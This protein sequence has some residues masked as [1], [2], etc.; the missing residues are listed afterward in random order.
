[1]TE[2]EIVRWLVGLG[3]LV[4]SWLIGWVF[5]RILAGRLHALASRTKSDLDDLI[6]GALQPHI[7]LW[8]LMG[9]IALAARHFELTPTWVRIVDRAMQAAFILSVSFAVSSFLTRLVAKRSSLYPDALPATSL[10][11]NVVR[12]V[13]VGL[14]VMMVVSNLGI[15]ITPI[16]TALGVGSLAVALALQPT[17][18][19]LFAGF[20]VT[21]ARQIR[22]GDYVELESGEKGYVTDIGWR[23]TE[24]RE[25]PN[26]M[27]IVPN[28]RI[29]EIIVKNFS[30]PVNEQAAL[31]QVGVS[32]SSDLEKVER[33]TID[34]AKEVQRSVTGAVPEFEPFIRYNQFGDSSVNFTVILRVREFVDRYAVSHE[35]IKRLHRRYETEDIEIP[36]PQRVVHFA[37]GSVRVEQA[38]GSRVGS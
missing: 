32:Y 5:R 13:V 29:A 21:L 16:L 9:G 2:A 27:I 23:N 6:L 35:F 14:G 38:P 26:N 12:I 10:T 22:V 30:L 31:I 8:F 7:P 4:G 19:N 24:I 34:V 3:I 11:Q 15:A 28:A 1:M 20:H 17:L 37:S 33:V 18:T 25:L 36:F